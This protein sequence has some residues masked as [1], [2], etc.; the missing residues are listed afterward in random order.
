MLN[1]EREE[2]LHTT[3]LLYNYFNIDSLNDKVYNIVV[4]PRY[5]GKWFSNKPNMLKR[6][7][8][9]INALYYNIVVKNS[10]FFLKPNIKLEKCSIMKITMFKEIQIYGMRHWYPPIMLEPALPKHMQQMK[11]W[12]TRL[13]NVNNYLKGKIK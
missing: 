8:F 2:F 11:Q 9:I 12:I 5:T 7:Y 1:S 13:N 4:V 6:R 3:K 10:Y